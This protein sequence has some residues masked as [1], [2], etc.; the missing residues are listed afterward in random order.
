MFEKF[1]NFEIFETIDKIQL[2]VE[3]SANK[4]KAKKEKKIKNKDLS[5]NIDTKFDGLFEKNKKNKNKDIY[6][7]IYEQKGSYEEQKI[8]DDDSDDEEININRDIKSEIITKP[9]KKN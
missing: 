9:K 4:K 5:M 6:D 7:D 3:K 2:E 8:M 1:L